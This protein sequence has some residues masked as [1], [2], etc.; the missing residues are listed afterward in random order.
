MVPGVIRPILAAGGIGAV[1]M[2]HGNTGDR[3][4]FNP[5]CH[6]DNDAM[7]SIVANGSRFGYG[8]NQARDGLPRLFLDADR[9]DDDCRVEDFRIA[10]EGHDAEVCMLF[11]DAVGCAEVARF[12]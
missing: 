9:V 12:R 1:R 5:R 7:S 10:G 6:N 2:V 11:R 4:A 3:V 8:T